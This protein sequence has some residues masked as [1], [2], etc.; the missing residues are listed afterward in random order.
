MQYM[1]RRTVEHVV[2]R[3]KTM[4]KYKKGIIG[5]NKTNQQKWAKDAQKRLNLKIKSNYSKRYVNI[6]NGIK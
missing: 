4:G 6:K 1:D 3:Q 5:D 2:I